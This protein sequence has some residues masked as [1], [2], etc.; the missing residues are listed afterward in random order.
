MITSAYGVFAVP[1]I[2]LWIV[3]FLNAPGIRISILVMSALGGLAGPISEYW[4]LRDYWHPDYLFAFNVG[5]WHFGAEDYIFT[6]ALAGIVMALF[7]KFS[8]KKNG[9]AF[10]RFHGNV[11]FGWTWSEIAGFF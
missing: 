4:H 8:A 1:F 9:A 7:E 11:C 5:G 2:L 10:L 3:L 6:F